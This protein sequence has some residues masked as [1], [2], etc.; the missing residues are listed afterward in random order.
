MIRTCWHLRNGMAET[1]DLCVFDGRVKGDF[2]GS[3]IAARHRSLSSQPVGGIG[4][5]G[6][7]LR[8]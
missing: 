6:D 1:T 3:P 8:V 2:V 7:V 4:S 5:C